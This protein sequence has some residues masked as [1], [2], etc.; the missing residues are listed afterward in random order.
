MSWLDRTEFVTAAEAATRAPSMLNSQ[1]WR[2]RFGDDEIDVL[3]YPR[4][5]LQAADASGW[6]ARIGCGAALFNL[7]LA[8][9]VQGKPANVRMLPDY[10]DP[11]LLARLTLQPPRPPTP[12]ELRLHRAIPRRH[13]N[14]APFTDK[15]V[16]LSVRAQLVDAARRERLAGPACRSHRR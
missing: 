12:A 11:H 9:A 15:P 3:V 2:F 13:S 4:R 10:D 5:H 14:R 7:R 1:P 8:L 16:P 6:A